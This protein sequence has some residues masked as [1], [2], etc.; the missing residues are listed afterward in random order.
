M[1]GIARK[2]LAIQFIHLV[3][4]PCFVCTSCCPVCLLVTGFRLTSL[5]V[6]ILDNQILPVPAETEEEKKAVYKPPV[7][8]K[9]TMIPQPITGT[10]DKDT[11]KLRRFLSELIS[12]TREQNFPA[13]HPLMVKCVQIEKALSEVR[14]SFQETKVCLV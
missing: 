3:E 5:S 4:T 7:P 13:N 9:P 2:L 12:L 11:E 1:L 14:I 6:D 8:E 10:N